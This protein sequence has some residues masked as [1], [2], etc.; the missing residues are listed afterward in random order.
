MTDNERSRC[1]KK[2]YM[3][4]N[5][6]ASK[7]TKAEATHRRTPPYTELAHERF[8]CNSRYGTR[9]NND[10]DDKITQ[11]GQTDRHIDME[12]QTMWN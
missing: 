8:A 3:G 9:S 11:T 6:Q 2:G 5:Q 12:Q 1:D 7:P 4:V 10:H